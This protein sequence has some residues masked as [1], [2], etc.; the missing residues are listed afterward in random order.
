MKS[1][2]ARLYFIKNHSSEKLDNNLSERLENLVL[3]N[4]NKNLDIDKLMKDISKIIDWNKVSNLQYMIES[5]KEPE[6]TQII[7]NIHSWVMNTF[8]DSLNNGNIE[9][10]IISYMLGDYLFL[11]PILDF[12]WKNIN[13]NTEKKLLEL[14]TKAKIDIT[15]PE[16]APYA[17]KK[18]YND[19]RKSLT[20]GSLREIFDFL[21]AIEHGRGYS[22]HFNEFISALTNISYKINPNLITQVIENFEPIL[23]KMLFNALSPYQVSNILRNYNKSVIFPLIIGL[24]HIINP[25]WNN[26]YNNSLEKDYTFIKE[27]STIVKKISVVSETDNLYKYITECSNIFGNKLWHSIYITFAIY[28]PN[29]LDSYINS[30]DFSLGFGAEN[31]FEIFCQFLSDESILDDFSTKLYHNYLEYLLKERSY[32]RNYCGT[33]YLEFLVR[34]AYVKS[35]KSHIKYGELLREVSMDFERALYSWDKKQISMYFTRLIIWVLALSFFSDGV[36]K[37]A[38]DL[39]YTI[40]I[41]SNEKYLG[42]FNTSIE[43]IDIDYKIFAD[44]LRNPKNYIKIVLPLSYNTHIVIEFNK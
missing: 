15:I 2:K 18:Y 42:V 41:F 22:Y 40:N 10:L 14:F 43:N 9:K 21:S 13:I 34:A 8:N 38:V 12:Q 16:K 27:V 25:T 4:N 39:S 7:F 32:V 6:N 31:V 24:V 11:E 36:I 37:D 30:I 23:V 17:E 33:N 35:E 5:N 20:N 1:E 3:F 29:F 26:M 44:Y 28:N 19:Y